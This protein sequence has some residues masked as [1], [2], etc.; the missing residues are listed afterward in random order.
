[1]L[2]AIS[3]GRRLFEDIERFRGLEIAGIYNRIRTEYI[4]DLPIAD[5]VNFVIRTGSVLLRENEAGNTF[6]RRQGESSILRSVFF[7]DELDDH[8]FPLTTKLHIIVHE[9]VHVIECMLLLIPDP[10]TLPDNYRYNHD[11]PEWTSVSAQVQRILNV[12]EI[13]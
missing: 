5:Q 2:E 13:Q 9:I 7:L 6:C 1:M 4:N 12:D 8:D 10:S 11:S 3:P